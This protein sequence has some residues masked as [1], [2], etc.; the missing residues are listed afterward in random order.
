MIGV[1]RHKVL[2]VEHDEKWAE[3]FEK[4]KLTLVNIHGDNV[5]DIQHVGSTAIKGIMAK[6]ML[7][8]AIVFKSVSDSV[9]IKMKKNGYEYFGE[10]VSGK[11][12]FVLRGEGEVSLQHIHCYEE[13]NLEHFYDQIKFRDF[14]RSHPEYA[15][16]YE[17]LKQEL[18]KIYFNDRKKY[19]EG[20]QAFFNKIKQLVDENFNK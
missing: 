13:K 8:I 9:F 3:E 12:L 5:V 14:I 16:E 7:D 10:V 15:K 19:T 11:H 1:P 4:T 18:F 2:L 17:L 20:K 6:P